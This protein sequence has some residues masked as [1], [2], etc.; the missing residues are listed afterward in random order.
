MLTIKDIAQ[1]KKVLV[2]K[3]DLADM[4]GRNLNVFATKKDLKEIRSE[5]GRGF[6]LMA[7]KVKLQEVKEEISSLRESLQGLTVAV[8]SLAKVISDLRL[9]YVAMKMQ[10]NRHEE[11]I[12]KIAK[13][14]GISLEI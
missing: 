14:A 4:K 6:G 7:T 2:T 11:W 3:K 12:R 9:E 1:L 8:D 5:I 13:K 10:L